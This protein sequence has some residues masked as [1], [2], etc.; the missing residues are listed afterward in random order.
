MLRS[1]RC[2]DLSEGRVKKL[3][4]WQM[5]WIPGVRGREE[6]ARMTMNFGTAHH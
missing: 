2:L 6:E 5:G 4:S 3:G 1:G